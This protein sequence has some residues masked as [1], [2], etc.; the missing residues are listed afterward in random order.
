[1]TTEISIVNEQL[2]A[3][4]INQGNPVVVEINQVPNATI[5]VALATIGPTGLQGPQGEIGPANTLTIGTVV[6]GD[7]AAATITGTAP[8]QTLNLTLPKGDTGATGPQGL[9]GPQGIQ[10]IQGPKGDTGDQGIQGVKGDTGATGPQGLTGP[11]G[12]QGLT[13]PQGSVGATGATGA[14]GSQGPQGLTGPQGPAGANGTNGTNGV[15]VPTGGTSGQVLAK[16]SATDYDTH[17]ITVSGGGGGSG[18]QVNSDWN[19]TSGVEQILNKPTLGTAAAANSSDFAT[20]AQGAKADTA[21]QPNTTATLANL[22]ISGTLDVTGTVTTTSTQTLKVQDPL[23]YV[24]SGATSIN[25]LDQGLLGHFNNGTYQHTGLVRDHTDGKWKLFKGVTTEPTTVINWTQAVY[26]T[27]KVGTLESDSVTVNGASFTDTD[28]S[29]WNTAYGW[30][31]HASAGYLTGITSG[32]VTTALGFTPYSASNPN[33]YISSYTETDPVFTASPAHGITSTN[34]TNWNSA[35]SWG[36]H[37][38]AG[39][40]TSYTESDPVFVASAAHGITA[41]NITNWN[42]AYGWG[43]HASAGYLTTSTASSTYQPLD[44]DLTSIAGL[45]GTSG[46]LKKTAAN[47][48]TLDTNTY[49]TSYTETDPVF[50]A[51]AAS[52]ITSTNITN[53]NTAYGWGNHASAG[54]LTSSAIG[55][56]VQAYDADLTSWAAILPSAKQDTLVSGTSIKTINSTSLLGSGDLVIGGSAPT[57]YYFRK[58]TATTLT[59]ATGN[60]SIFGLTSGVTVQANTIYEVECEF[61]LTTSGTTSHTEA[62]GFTLATATV[63]NMS[64]A[65]NRLAGSTTSSALGAYLTSVTPVA[66][67]GALTT[68]QTGIYKVHGTIAFGTGGSINPVIAFSAAPGGTST[69]VL[70][71]WMKV[72]AIGTTGANVSTGTWA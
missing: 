27:L 52:G 21:I 10:G 62:F 11:Q 66:V 44:A 43:N 46:I 30:G 26:D 6:K 45:A 57:Q 53:W 59:S 16:N 71:S 9:T 51:S 60:Q 47:T 49:L 5:E 58:N 50:S 41:T 64:V 32:Q 20:A 38:T 40:L 67:T 23:I 29:H 22:S 56:T 4:T 37:A 25:S 15:G 19:A 3:V 39:Y 61:Q 42:S 55:T 36:N 68:A 69:I 2:H 14:T 63:T 34:I 54:Y 13:G 12:P 35:Y 31:N 48:W 70:G 28:V 18:T 7:N 1:M 8:N 24:A 65:V 33:G 72:T 17:W